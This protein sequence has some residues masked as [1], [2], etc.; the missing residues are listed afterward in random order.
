MFLKALQ[1]VCQVW[2]LHCSRKLLQHLYL[3]LLQLVPQFHYNMVSEAHQL[4][5]HHKYL[6][7][8]QFQTHLSGHVPSIA[9]QAQDSTEW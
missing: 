9:E 1:R 3:F 6:A 5:C 2:P 8:V 4:Y 7:R